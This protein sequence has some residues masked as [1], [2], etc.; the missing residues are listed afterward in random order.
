MAG[1]IAA[2]ARRVLAVG[3]E[4]FAPQGEM[5]LDEAYAY[6][7]QVMTRN[8]AMADAQEGID[9]FLTK[10]APVWEG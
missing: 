3:K 2:K 5:S 8:M 7:A 6:T 9:A 10:R 4:A 1:R